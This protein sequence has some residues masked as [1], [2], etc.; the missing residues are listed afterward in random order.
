MKKLLAILMILCLIFSFTACSG[1]K[2]DNIS[3]TNNDDIYFGEDDEEI[4]IKEMP[5]LLG[6][7]E[8]VVFRKKGT[9]IEINDIT[10]IANYRVAVVLNSDSQLIGEYYCDAT[11]IAVHGTDH[12]AFSDLNSKN[13]DIA[14]CRKS[15]LDDRFEI[16]LDPIELIELK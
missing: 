6:D 2:K 7:E 13:V 14:I 9:D 8:Y 10:E 3:S 12:D 5:T 15:A 4:E 16:I 11:N 1:D